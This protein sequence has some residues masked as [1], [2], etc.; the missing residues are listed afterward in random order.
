MVWHG[1]FKG[2][3]ES[4]NADCL[5]EIE[6]QVDGTWALKSKHGFYAH[7]TGDKMSCFTKEIPADGK[8]IV[9]LAMH[10]QVNVF[11]VN[12]NRYVHLEGDSLC[13]NEDVPWGADALVTF[14]FFSDH[15]EGRYGFIASNGKYLNAN[16]SLQA[17][18]N[19]ACQF[20]LGLHDDQ[21]SLRDSKGNYLSCV[22]GNGVLKVGKQKVTKDELFVIQD[23]E[24]QFTITSC[25][26]NKYV[27]LRAGEEV[28][29]D[30]PEVTDGELFQLELDSAGKVS[31]KN[32]KRLYWTVNSSNVLECSSKTKEA[33][34][35]FTVEYH[36][37]TVKFVAPNGK[38]LTVKPSGAMIANGDGSEAEAVFV[39]SLINRPQMMLRG[40]YGFCGIKG[41]SGRIE[42]NKSKGEVFTLTACNGCYNISDKYGKFWSYDA[43]G[44]HCNSASPMEFYLEFVERSKCVIKTADGKYLKGEQAGGFRVNGTK[45]EINT[46]WE[47]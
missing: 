37:K 11:G 29:A 47:Y 24:P 16:G 30:Q 15:P 25:S 32:C 28:K 1:S 18:P 35:K 20:L 43:D 45:P 44:V 19:E 6:A 2:D 13:C 36:G 46:L 9:H 10:P 40:Q 14:V 26:V 17:E 41:D 33:N 39:M 5:W 38:Y 31:F 12:R 34:E 27:S 8:W 22:G 23:S 4:P 21:V 7:G 42:V 3:A